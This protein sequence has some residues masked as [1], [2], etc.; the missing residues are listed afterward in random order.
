MLHHLNHKDKTM[1]LTKEQLKQIIKEELESIME[2]G[3]I[4]EGSRPMAYYNQSMIGVQ[5][6]LQ[7]DGKS[8]DFRY[9]YA[10]QYADNIMK[11]IQQRLANQKGKTIGSIQGLAEGILAALE[12]RFKGASDL[13]TL[14]QLKSMPVIFG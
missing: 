5:V 4:E 9:D 10:D 2:D 14:E 3:V 12:R 7:Y 8:V 1:K 11:A 13:P 6:E